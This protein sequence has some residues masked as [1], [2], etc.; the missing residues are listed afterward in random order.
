MFGLII[1]GSLIGVVCNIGV[2]QQQVPEPH[3]GYRRYFMLHFVVFLK[4]VHF[5]VIT[6]ILC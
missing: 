6:W 2:G 1:F 3:T 5:A 4:G